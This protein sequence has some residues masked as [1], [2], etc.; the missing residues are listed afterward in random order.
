[1]KWALVVLIACNPPD[2]GP[3]FVAAGNPKPIDGG[4]LRFASKDGIGKLD[5]TVEYEEVSS[6][7]V[8][9]IYETLIDYETAVRGN[10]A[11]G[12][13]IV[14]RLASRWSISSDALEYHFW[15]RDGITFSDGT[16][17]V[18]GDFVY[19]LERVLK[20]PTSPFVGYLTDIAG[21]AEVIA[22]Q[23]AHCS[24]IT[25]PNDHEVVIR[26]AQRNMAFLEILTMSFATPQRR[27]F[28]ERVGDQIQ[29]QTLGT[30]PFMLDDWQ[31]GRRI[32]LKRNPR[33]W[34]ASSIHLDRIEFLE[35]VP[36][37]TQFLMF[38][39]GELDSA[40][41]LT[42]PDYL[43]LIAQKDWAP[44]VQTRPVMNAYGSRMN[45]TVPP[46]NDRRVRQALNYAVDKDHELK[47]LNGTATVSHGIL[48]PGVFGR[49][50][51][52][53]P[54]PHDPAKARAL[55]AEAGFPFGFEAD[56]VIMNDGEAERLATSL[57]SDL[58]EV[59][60]QLHVSI[61][62]FATYVT[63]IGNKTGAPFSKATWVADFPD[64]IN[65]LDAR[66]TVAMIHDE[67]TN[68]DS[69][70]SNPELET[71][72]AA[73]RGEV[74]TDKR[75]AMYHRAEKI[76]FDDAPWIWEYHQS[77]TEVIQPYVAGYS[78]HPIWFRDYSRAWLDR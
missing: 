61:T 16:P 73:A 33:Y 4:T 13:K 60:V 17:V 75:E 67:G 1:M 19:S 27:E 6:Y 5:P 66:F 54:Y 11:S 7:A 49:D 38:E 72:L 12:F 15:L 46:F 42:S 56:Y 51:T 63:E 25:T 32:V 2:R 18:A 41:R 62:S 37:D 55:L 10:E 65:F 47:L 26:L 30:G 3:K 45:V 69:W 52:L 70:Y 28:V 29:S 78:L 71:L 36:R 64:P 48:P 58:A 68:N 59:G 24:G 57:Q 23:A 43:W 77:M 34:D 9:A 53:A 40:E 44:Y 21:S 74:D 14:P 35:N 20:E 76:V 50:D 8:H 22:H 39:S 31:Q